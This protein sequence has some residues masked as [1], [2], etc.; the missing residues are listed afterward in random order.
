MDGKGRIMLVRV[1][2]ACTWNIGHMAMGDVH[3]LAKV[4]VPHATVLEVLEIGM[5]LSFFVN[6]EDPPSINYLS[7]HSFSY[8]LTHWVFEYTKLHRFCVLYRSLSQ[9]P[10]L[11][12]RQRKSDDN[13]M[14]IFQPPWH[15]ANKVVV[16][17]VEVH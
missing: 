13:Q 9:S 17:R 11:W 2:V 14:I 3:S 10:V 16:R 1:V 6:F 12:L 4:D 7:Q 15:Q 8:C 5:I